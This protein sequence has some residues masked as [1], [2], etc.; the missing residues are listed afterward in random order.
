METR[1]HYLWLPPGET[2]PEV[3]AL[4][5]FKA[6]VVLAADYSANWQKVVSD[7]LVASGCRYMMAWGPDSTTWDDSVDW[8]DLEARNFED[9]DSRFV[10]TT[11]HDKE[12]L[13]S[14]FWYSQF[15]AN[16]SYDD[17]PLMNALIVDISSKDREA[18]LLHLFNQ[19]ESLAERD[20]G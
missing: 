5:P 15:C 3:S 11:W 2:P 13:E 12:T 16:F 10:M 20:P 9:D 8:A 17:V 6:V 18:E 4:A 19:S 1:P 14:A 7:W